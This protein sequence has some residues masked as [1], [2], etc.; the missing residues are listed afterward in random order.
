MRPAAV[1]VADVVPRRT[2]RLSVATAASVAT[3]SLGLLAQSQPPVFKASVDLIAVDLQ[4]VEGDGQ[5]VRALGPNDFTVS[6]GGKP[7]RVVS[8]EFIESASLNGSAVDRPPMVRRVEGGPVASNAWPAGGLRGTG[9]TYV[10]AFDT[11]SFSIGESRDVVGAARG[12]I[13][14]LQPGDAVGVYTF[15]IG[16]RLEPTTNHADASRLV[17]TVVGQLQHVP[18][19]FNL[20]PS[21]IID[22][23]AELGRTRANN[24]GRGSAPTVAGGSEGE[25]T[26]RVQNRECGTTDIRCVDEIQNEAQSMAFYL[27]GRAT[28]GLNGLRALIRLLNAEP[29]RKTVVL[30]SAGILS[31]DRPGGRPEVGELAKQ[32]GQDAAATN[33]TIYVVH[34][35]TGAWRQMA[36]E[37]RKTDNPPVSR[38]RDNAVTGRLLA[39]FSGASGGTLLRVVMGG[40]EWALDRV[41]RETSSHYLLGVEPAESDRDGKLRPLSVKVKQKGTTVRSRLWVAVPKRAAP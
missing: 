1:D 30:F 5:P 14:Q 28:T 21:E 33:T 17:D 24:A 11:D 29:G 16:P 25:V 15:P 39:E 27:E 3:L 10:L 4:V 36:A 35:D 40:G 8:A 38:S 13:Q 32:L 23:N 20:T 7:R 2:R 22:I 34:L 12:F 37:T 31:T 19:D 9:R 26:R 6:I 41:L 18:G